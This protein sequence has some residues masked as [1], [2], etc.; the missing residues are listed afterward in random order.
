MSLTKNTGS[1]LFEEA[2]GPL[3]TLFINLSGK[4]ADY[5]FESLKKMLRKEEIPP[6]PI[7]VLEAVH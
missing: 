5:W 1:M 4:H 6:P 2:R 3:T 7:E